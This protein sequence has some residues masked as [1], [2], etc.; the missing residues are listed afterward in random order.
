MDIKIGKSARTCCACDRGFDHEEPL[1]S[2]LHPNDQDLSRSDYC[3]A[4]WSKQPA[5]KPYST[6]KSTFFDPDA[7]DKYLREIVGGEIAAILLGGAVGRYRIAVLGFVFA[8]KD[9]RDVK[10]DRHLRRDIL[11]TDHERLERMEEFF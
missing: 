3:E 8:V 1:T 9:Q 11:L 5:P 6:W 2:V 10:I 7:A 4:C